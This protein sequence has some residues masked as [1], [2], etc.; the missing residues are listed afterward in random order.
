MVNSNGLRPREMLTPG[1]K[2]EKVAYWYFR[3]NGFLQIE[4]FV[5]HPGRRGGQRSDAD[6]LALRFPFR[7]E[8]LFDMEHPMRD[9]VETLRLSPDLIEIVIAEIKTNE[10][11]GLNGPW[12]NN[13]AENIHRVLAAIGCLRKDDEI[14]SAASMIYENGAV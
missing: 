4:N 9:D 5:I 7:R 2:P 11:C 10:P 1:L 14:R 8:F 6:L 3:L 13:D 12:T